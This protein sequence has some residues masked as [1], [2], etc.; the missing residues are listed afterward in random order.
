MR[1]PRPSEWRYRPERRYT[2][3]GANSEWI[4]STDRD[5]AQN[6]WRNDW[7]T[8]LMVLLLD[9]RLNCFRYV[10]ETLELLIL[11]L[12]NLNI[13]LNP[14]LLWPQINPFL[15]HPD[16]TLLTLRL[17]QHL[18]DSST[19]NRSKPLSILKFSLVRI[20]RFPTTPLLPPHL[21]SPFMCFRIANKRRLLLC[22]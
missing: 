11:P 13:F 2:S 8:R 17:P 9:L 20:G 12:H 21:L 18:R 5:V 4:T 22:H 10:F 15:L 3:V 16:S 6:H 19:L 7:L 1:A 14:S